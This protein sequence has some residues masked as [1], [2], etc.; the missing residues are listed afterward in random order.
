M[1]LKHKYEELKA[2]SIP[3]D[4]LIAK[5][6]NEMRELSGF[7]EK[8]IKEKAE[9]EG[10]SKRDKELLQ[11][12]LVEYDVLARDHQDLMN[13]SKAIHDKL[14]LSQSEMTSL[15]ETISK[16][17]HRNNI[18]E[19]SA[20]ENLIRESRRVEQP[21]SK[22]KPFTG[23]KT[24]DQSTPLKKR[25]HHP[26]Y[27]LSSYTAAD[28]GRDTLGSELGSYQPH[29]STLATPR[30]LS[31]SVTPAVPDATKASTS[32][33]RRQLDFSSS[34]A[35][36]STP[37]S[38]GKRKGLAT[39][40]NPDTSQSAPYSAPAGMVVKKTDLLT[41][42]D[43]VFEDSKSGEEM[44]RTHTGRTRRLYGE[45]AQTETSFVKGTDEATGGIADSAFS[46][47]RDD[48]D[49]RLLAVEDWESSRSEPRRSK[50]KQSVMYNVAEKEFGAKTGQPVNKNRDEENDKENVRLMERKFSM[51][52]EERKRLESTLSRIP[53]T[54]KVSKRA[55]EDKAYLENRLYD[56]VKDIGTVRDQLRRQNVL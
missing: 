30:M 40:E 54:Q 36:A 19:A 24:W 42:F 41:R 6:E 29:D 32:S 15:R 17:V 1:Q 27:Q 5:L 39:K 46:S 14:D 38:Q 55:K 28:S 35:K 12:M 20:K 56:V 10:N 49:G 8:T 21:T 45:P 43:V 22:N 31:H 26:Q 47:V 53:A 52:T 9:A 48:R 4:E 25:G 44:V 50:D 33:G 7:V 18:L 2:M 37:A 51:L 13:S 34:G 16:L 11:R 3:K 23:R